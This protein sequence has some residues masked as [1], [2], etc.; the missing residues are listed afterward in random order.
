[1][2][3]IN[4]IATPLFVFSCA[5]LKP[6]ILFKFLLKRRSDHSSGQ[7]FI[8]MVGAV[9]ADKMKRAAEHRFKIWYKERK[10][11]MNGGCFHCNLQDSPLYADMKRT[12]HM[13]LYFLLNVLQR[14]VAEYWVSSAASEPYV[15]MCVATM[16]KGPPS[17]IA[18]LVYL[19]SPSLSPPPVSAIPPTSKDRSFWSELAR[20]VARLQASAPASAS[21]S[22]T[23]ANDEDESAAFWSRLDE[24]VSRLEAFLPVTNHET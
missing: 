17:I 16:S 5:S 22:A 23:A 3:P 12:P 7:V 19:K 18:L 24:N 20:A 2:Q 13:L 1:M 4:V 11:S 8:A 21:M 15:R 14:L 9:R 10:A 6:C